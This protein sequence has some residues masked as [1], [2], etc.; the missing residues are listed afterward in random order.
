[1]VSN[2]RHDDNDAFG[3]HDTY[4]IAPA[5]LLPGIETKLK[6]SYG[7]GFKAPSLDQLYGS[8]DY[9]YYGGVTLG[10]P[11]LRPEES[12]GWD[13]GFEQPIAGDRF[14]FGATYFHNDITNLVQCI[15]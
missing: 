12:K 10:N 13:A 15:T 2:V 9:G 3:G 8:Y 14:R 1:M 4:R 6:A 11:N 5:V 7:T